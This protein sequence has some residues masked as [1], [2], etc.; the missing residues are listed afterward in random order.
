MKGSTITAIAL[1]AL[2]AGIAVTWLD[3]HGHTCDRCGTQWS[4]FGRFNVGR[5]DAHR[6]SSCGYMQWWKDGAPRLTQLKG[7]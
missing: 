6:C 3:P 1:V 5:D 7:T 2:G 4:H